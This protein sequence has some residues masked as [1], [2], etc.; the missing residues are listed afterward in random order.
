MSDKLVIA[1]EM[2][3]AFYKEQTDNG[4]ADGCIWEYKDDIQLLMIN[5]SNR[6]D[7]EST[8]VLFVNNDVPSDNHEYK[9]IY[10]TKDSWSWMYGVSIIHHQHQNQHF[11]IDKTLIH[12]QIENPCRTTNLKD[13][14]GRTIWGGD[15]V[16]KIKSPRNKFSSFLGEDNDVLGIVVYNKYTFQ[17]LDVETFNGTGDPD[18][19][20]DSMD[21]VLFYIQDKIEILGNIFDNPDILEDLFKH[22]KDVELYKTYLNDMKFY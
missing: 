7:E 22:C 2:F 15:I 18:D 20:W 12:H 8:T 4:T 14:N 17:A 13:K 11:L 3:D 1:G 21:D 5:F 19:P 9:G 10:K 6:I 16:R